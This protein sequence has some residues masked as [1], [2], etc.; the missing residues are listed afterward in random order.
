MRIM[1]IEDGSHVLYELFPPKKVLFG[2]PLRD[3]TKDGCEGDYPSDKGPFRSEVI[4][5]YCQ[6][7]Y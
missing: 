6:I 3:I 5:L 7:F 2:G 4:I 1:L